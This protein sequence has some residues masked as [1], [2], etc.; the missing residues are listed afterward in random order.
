MMEECNKYLNCHTRIDACALTKNLCDS[1]INCHT[2]CAVANAPKKEETPLN[3]IPTC[4]LVEELSSRMGVDTL[5]I[6]IH[7]AYRITAIYPNE[8]CFGS[9]EGFGPAHILIIND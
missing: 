5:S 3:H 9:K 8:M 6:P 4:K 1:G 2:C 7:D